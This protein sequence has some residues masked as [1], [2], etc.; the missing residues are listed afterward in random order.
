MATATKATRKRAPVLR[1]SPLQIRL[2]PEEKR[3]FVEAAEREHLSISAWLRL[4][5]LHAAR[6]NHK[7]K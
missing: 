1:E 7:V 2:T 3:I 4:A 5:G 6:T